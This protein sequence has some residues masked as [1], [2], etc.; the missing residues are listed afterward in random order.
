M[1]GESTG[2]LSKCLKIAP[3][4]H[5]V[6][7]IMVGYEMHQDFNLIQRGMSGNE[8]TLPVSQRFEHH[9]HVVVKYSVPPTRRSK[10]QASAD[11]AIDMQG[12]ILSV[13]FKFRQ[14]LI[15]H[16]AGVESRDL[17]PIVIC[18]DGQKQIARAVRV[19]ERVSARQVRIANRRAFQKGDMQL[20]GV[21]LAHVSGVSIPPAGA[22]AVANGI[23]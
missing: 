4:L 7:P 11:V 17:S 13:I 9:A 14:D 19:G 8:F 22:L 20:G 23:L 16:Q 15:T 1:P 12:G 5:L 18:A 10:D 3:I 6:I 2:E 21:E